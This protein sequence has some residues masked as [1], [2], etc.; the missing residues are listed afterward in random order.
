MLN[1]RPYRRKSYLSDDFVK[2]W[3]DTIQ[4]GGDIASGL[5]K[6]ADKYKSRQEERQKLTEQATY[7]QN[8]DL[9]S[10]EEAYASGQKYVSGLASQFATANVSLS[11]GT[12]SDILARSLEIAELQRQANA[13]HH[14]EYIQ[15][16]RKKERDLGNP[17][18]ML[19]DILEEGLNISMRILLGT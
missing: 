9:A 17:S 10:A 14:A 6:V 3:G 1:D 12:T 18:H 8:E 4:T 16:L 11:E 15:K 7:L 2:K 5:F 19:T 13:T